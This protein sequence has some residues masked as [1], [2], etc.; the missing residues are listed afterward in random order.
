MVSTSVVRVDVV[1]TGGASE[2]YDGE[3][4]VGGGGDDSA[5]VSAIFR[6]L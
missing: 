5:A 3:V 4:G 2:I 6:I 1:A